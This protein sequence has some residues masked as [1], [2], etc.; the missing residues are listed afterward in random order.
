[1]KKLFT[2]F[3]LILLPL[4]A[5]ADSVEIDG[6]C[7]SLSTVVNSQT[8]VVTYEAT[9]TSNGYTGEIVIPE[10]VTYNEVVY[11]VKAI[12]D[13]A[14][15]YCSGLTSVTIPNSVTSIGYYAFRECSGLTSVT[16]PSSVT[17][18]GSRVFDDCSGLTSMIVEKGN[19]V[20]DSRN[21]CNAIIES[22]S[23]TLIF[24]CKNTIIPNDVTSIGEYAFY[25]CS[26][27]TSV[28]IPN[29][30]TSIGSYA[31]SGC[32]GLTSITI[33]NSVT[34]IGSSAFLNCS[35]L[36]SIIVE[37]GNTIYDS[38]ENCSA[39]IE[40]E[41]NTLITGCKNTVI[42]NSVTSIGDAA[43]AGCSSLTSITIPNSVTSIDHAAFSHCSSLTSITIPN[44]VTSIGEYAFH[45]CSGLTSV[46]IPNSVSSI[47][48]GA[49]SHCCSLTSIT[50]PN[51][52][53][54]IG[55]YAFSYCIGLTSLTIP[56]SVTSIGDGAFI[57]CSGLTSV[58]IPISVTSI[59]TGVFC[60]CSGLTSVTIPNSVTNI[61]EEMFSGCS[62]LTS[63][64]IGSE[65]MVIEDFSF[66]DCP[67]LADF[68][69]FAQKVPVI[70]YNAF[71]DTNIGNI[72]LH[73][74]ASSIEAYKATVPWYRFKEIVA[75]KDDEVIE[76]DEIKISNIGQTTWCSAYDLDFTDVEGLKAYIAS[77][78]HRTNG[79]IWLTSV[80]EV[81][82][83]EGILLI[84]DP[85]VYM[86]P[87][88]STTAYYANLMVG[89]VEAKTI[90][91]TDGEYTNYYLSNGSYGVGFYKVY[92]SIEINANRAYLPLLKSTTSGSRGFIGLD[93]EDGEE[94]TTGISEAPQRL[95]EMDVYYNLQGQ[96]VDCPSKGI[97]IHNGKKVV[98]K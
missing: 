44:D 19:T 38:R 34:S 13:N 61:R 32:S 2:I 64:T 7:Y 31:F 15:C 77:G 92:G 86:V 42:P 89:T 73:V 12:G 39:I 41:R 3:L 59:G 87:H 66:K 58:T 54:S 50:I 23:N 48:N 10:S 78:Y 45:E 53:T 20:Y 6:I 93:F 4:V 71:K 33:P 18:I 68:Y 85:G 57:V 16:I 80:K 63:V 37:N 5:S 35:G 1:M 96:R 36:T 84:G 55:K 69:C 60:G 70:Y 98:I 83:G 75:I 43:F 81:P 28:T 8:S 29:S 94:G 62:S 56:N 91:E 25:E 9:V 27:L 90:N 26:D 14:F 46:T 40:T 67:E 17:S 97:F 82:A 30:V 88:K 52:V 22:S 76:G 47:D 11:N 21:N 72:T 24:G 79:T 74:P 95:A 51:S 49:F 65:V